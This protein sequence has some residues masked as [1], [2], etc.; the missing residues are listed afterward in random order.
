MLAELNVIALRDE[1]KE[2]EEADEYGN[3]PLGYFY[4][5]HCERDIDCFGN[6]ELINVNDLKDDM[7]FVKDDLYFAGE[8][9]FLYT[10]KLIT[11]LANGKKIKTVPKWLTEKVILTRYLLKE[12]EKEVA[13]PKKKY[14]KHKYREIFLITDKEPVFIQYDKWKKGDDWIEQWYNLGLTFY[15]PK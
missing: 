10:R 6:L 13:H 3:D 8:L 2:D 11:Q 5:D 1:E 7:R 14:L 12:A 4:P 9:Q 15:L